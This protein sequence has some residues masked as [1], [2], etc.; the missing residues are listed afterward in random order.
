MRIERHNT[1]RL[2]NAARTQQ[3]FCCANMCSPCVSETSHAIAH[4]VA[5]A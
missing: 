1:E 4:I 3:Y 2:S 5:E